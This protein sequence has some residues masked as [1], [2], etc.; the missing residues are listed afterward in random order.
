MTTTNYGEGMELTDQEEKEMA[1]YYLFNDLHNI[2]LRWNEEIP[3]NFVP[4]IKLLTEKFEEY[5]GETK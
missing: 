1:L 5:Y 4:I 2:K 3:P